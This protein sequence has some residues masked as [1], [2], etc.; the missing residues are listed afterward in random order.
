[1]AS[2]IDRLCPCAKVVQFSLC[3]CFPALHL[4][5]HAITTVLISPSKAYVHIAYL[6]LRTLA[7]KQTGT[8]DGK[9]VMIVVEHKSTCCSIC[10]LVRSQLELCASNAVPEAPDNVTIASNALCIYFHSYSGVTKGVTVLGLTAPSW[11]W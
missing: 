3:W 7:V 2:S 1:M 11:I 9:F 5:Q 10:D 6:A 8:T 4:E